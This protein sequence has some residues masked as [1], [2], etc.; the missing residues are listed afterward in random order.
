MLVVS[1]HSLWQGKHNVSGSTTVVVAS[2][3]VEVVGSIEVVVV[4]S[5]V[6]EVLVPVEDVVIITVVVGS[7]VVVCAYEWLSTSAHFS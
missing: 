2:M 5:G 3:V 4:V 6:V 1:S 7:T